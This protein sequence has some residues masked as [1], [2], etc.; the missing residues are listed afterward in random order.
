MFSV[1][2]WLKSQDDVFS[3]ISIFPYVTYVYGRGRDGEYKKKLF[4]LPLIR[5]LKF[6]ICM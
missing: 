6:D 3:L 1:F 2:L 4:P 5:F